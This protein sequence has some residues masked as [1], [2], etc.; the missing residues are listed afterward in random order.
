MRFRS[1]YTGT[2]IAVAITVTACGGTGTIETPHDP[3]EQRGSGIGLQPAPNSEHTPTAGQQEKNET[4]QSDLTARLLS[5]SSP[6]IQPIYRWLQQPP[7]KW[8]QPL[9]GG[10][11]LVW[12][13]TIPVPADDRIFVISAQGTD[14]RA[15]WSRQLENPAR[16]VRYVDATP[17]GERVAIV[18]RNGDVHVISTSDG[19]TV[20]TVHV[21][22]DDPDTDSVHLIADGRYLVVRSRT[23]SGVV[24]WTLRVYPVTPDAKIAYGTNGTA[25]HFS[26]YHDMVLGLQGLK[27]QG[28]EVATSS[29]FL[30]IIPYK[31]Q[32][33]AEDVEL[34]SSADGQLIYVMSRKRGLDVYGRD[35]KLRY[36]IDATPSLDV[37]LAPV[38][39]VIWHEVSPGRLEKIDA[40]G[41]MTPFTY[42]KQ[43]ITLGGTMPGGEQV[44]RVE[45]GGQKA[46]CVVKTDGQ[47]FGCFPFVGFDTATTDGGTFFWANLPDGTFA[48][49]KQ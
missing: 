38:D 16:S 42:D 8:Y 22:L 7:G 5:L 36:H 47:V 12:T 10:I 35:L 14:G 31:H 23:R 3:I 25:V 37:D 39:K 27:E 24:P 28:I 19:K 32:V 2:L 15:L 43:K 6:S 33:Q 18:E 17:S 4:Q 26:P 45:A 46:E 49:Y 21:E 30:G 1:L 9:P 11:L 29:G 48:A 44:F 20:A 34:S 41:K 13:E 40:S